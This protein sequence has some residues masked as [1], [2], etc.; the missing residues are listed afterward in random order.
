MDRGGTPT[1]STA[2]PSPTPAHH[3]LPR[4]AS[5]YELPEGDQRVG[6]STPNH[7][8]ARCKWG[9]TPLS[10]MNTV[11]HT[12]VM[13]CS[14]TAETHPKGGVSC[15]PAAALGPAADVSK[16]ARAE[17]EPDDPRRHTGAGGRGG[18]GGGRETTGRS[19]GL[20]PVCSALAWQEPKIKPPSSSS[21]GFPA[22]QQPELSSLLMCL[23]VLVHPWPDIRHRVESDAVKIGTRCLLHATIHFNCSYEVERRVHAQISCQT[24]GQIGRGA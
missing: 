16:R 22:G 1:S 14:K 24:S 12:S 7:P 18:T 15:G 17:T 23:R 6:G 20:G 9:P 5:T 19:E 3:Q 21:Y 11:F 10:S 4:G 2:S 13:P 8:A